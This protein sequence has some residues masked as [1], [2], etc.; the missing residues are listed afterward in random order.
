MKRTY[1][2]NNAGSSQEA[3]LSS[4]HVDPGRAG[5]PEGT[6][7]KGP[8]TPV[9]VIGRIRDRDR[10]PTRSA[11]KD[12]RA[13]AGA[14]VVHSAPRSTPRRRPR[15]RYA[16]GQARSVRRSSQPG[17]A[18]PRGDCGDRMRTS[19]IRA[20]YLSASDPAPRTCSYERAHT[21]MFDH[22]CSTS[23]RGATPRSNRALLAAIRLVP[24]S[25]RRTAVSLSL[26]A[27]L[28]VLRH[29]GA[30]TAYGTGRGVC[31][32]VRRFCAAARSARPG[33]TRCRSTTAVHPEGADVLDDPEPV[34]AALAPRLVLRASPQLRHRD[35]R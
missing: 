33:T 9:G 18:P 15:W 23:C 17:P 11:S 32:T 25:R 3:R 26:H 12:T 21:A 10:L 14:T 31:L 28:L 19:S 30:R 13:R 34:P 5:D 8:R 27:L 29:R 4:P 2:P 6:P 22:D 24:A 35:L 1:Q 16:I 7:W 20:G